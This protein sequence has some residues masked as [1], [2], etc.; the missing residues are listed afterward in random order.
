[1]KLAQSLSKPKENTIALINV[2]FLM[3]VFFM[4]AGPLAPPLDPELSLIKAQDLE[5][6]APPD[7]LVIR[8]DGTMW[9]RDVELTS[10]SA[11]LD[12]VPGD[13]RSVVRI[14]PDRDLPALKLMAISDELRAGGAE[15]VLLISERGLK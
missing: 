3:L 4:I 2:V 13:D 15:R 12:R 1:M 11:F 5:G 6:R 7:T 8:E 14:V 9:L 10:A